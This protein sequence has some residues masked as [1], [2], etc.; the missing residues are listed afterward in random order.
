MLITL[1]VLYAPNQ[2]MPYFDTCSVLDLEE[3]NKDTCIHR[4]VCDECVCV[5]QNCVGFSAKNM[6]WPGVESFDFSVLAMRVQQDCIHYMCPSCKRR[7]TVTWKLTS[8]A[9]VKRWKW[10]RWNHAQRWER[11]AQPADFVLA[12]STLHEPRSILHASPAPPCAH[13]SC[14]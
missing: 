11:P 3:V 2:N 4:C 12:H 8:G 10:A 6:G 5:G 13:P 1:Y 9:V 7:I 14:R